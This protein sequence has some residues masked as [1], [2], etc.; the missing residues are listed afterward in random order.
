LPKPSWITVPNLD[1]TQEGFFGIRDFQAL[2]GEPSPG[3]P[4]GRS[5]KLKD[6]IGI[7]SGLAVPNLNLVAVAGA[8]CQDI[9]AK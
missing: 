9:D 4:D 1:V 8:T 7:R 3:P 2:F 5:F 6:V